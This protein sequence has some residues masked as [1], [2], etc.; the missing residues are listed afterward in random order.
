MQTADFI[1]VEDVEDTIVEVM[2]APPGPAGA[3]GPSVHWSTEPP[4]TNDGYV[5]DFWVVTE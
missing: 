2:D 3:D 1:F 5:G 4:T